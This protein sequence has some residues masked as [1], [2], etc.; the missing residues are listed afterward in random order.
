M[1]GP[2]MDKMILNEVSEAISNCESKLSSVGE[3]AQLY[4]ASHDE[5]LEK[6]TRDSSLIKK[7]I[8][9]RIARVYDNE[10]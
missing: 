4:I 10:G 2:V 5:Y 1:E 7:K 3:I 6:T 9:E 8:K